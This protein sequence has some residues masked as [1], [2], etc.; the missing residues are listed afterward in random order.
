MMTPRPVF[1]VIVMVWRVG[2]R[3]GEEVGRGGE[4][5]RREGEESG[6]GGEVVRDAESGGEEMDSPS[7]GLLLLERNAGGHSHWLYLCTGSSQEQAQHYT[8]SCQLLT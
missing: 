5:S 4:E 8:T 2:V 7:G 3:G 1:L 6:R